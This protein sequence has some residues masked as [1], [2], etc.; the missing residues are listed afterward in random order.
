MVSAIPY[1][2][3][4]ITET[5]DFSTFIK[6]S[7]WM[8]LAVL[9]KITTA[10]PA[11]LVIGFLV[12]INLFLKTKKKQTIF[13]KDILSLVAFILPTLIGAVWSF[14]SDL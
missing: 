5:D 1:A 4:L 9:Q 12:I 11:L 8:T 2:I 7:F 10:A 6:Y 14:Y 13:R 3:E